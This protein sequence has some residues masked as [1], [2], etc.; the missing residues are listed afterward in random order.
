MKHA[1]KNDGPAKSA[2]VLDREDDVLK[3]V[4]VP[5]SVD[6]VLVGGAPAPE[7][8]L[9]YANDEVLADQPL[10]AAAEMEADDE[11]TLDVPLHRANDYTNIWGIIGFV[12]SIVS[13]CSGWF[14][15]LGWLP[16]AVGLVISFIAVFRPPRAFAIA[17]LSVSGA[18]FII[19]MILLGMGLM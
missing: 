1:K 8:A 2:A 6:D 17:G 13:I 16:W 15:F 12:V 10:D 14:Y 9:A 3:G 18:Y 4:R 19:W 5:D 7:D 11:G